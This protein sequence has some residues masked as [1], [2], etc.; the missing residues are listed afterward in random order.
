MVSRFVRRVR[1]ASRA[2]AVQVVTKQAGEVLNV[3]HVG[4]AHSDDELVVLMDMAAARLR[5][6]QDA[7]DSVTWGI[8]GC[9]RRGWGTPLISLLL[10]TLCCRLLSP[11]LVQ[12]LVHGR[13][14]SGPF[15]V[16]PNPQ[17]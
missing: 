12:A 14:R 15:L 5:P 7:L 11:L 1:T 17:H 2:V 6:G 10:R 4:S 3:D 13:R 9:G 8:W 16:L